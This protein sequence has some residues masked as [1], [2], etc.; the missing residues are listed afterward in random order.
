MTPRRFALL[1]CIIPSWIALTFADEQPADR[2]E[3]V[4]KRLVQAI[5]AG[6]T[7]AFRRDFDKAMLDALPPE[8][9]SS[10]VKD[11]RGQ[12]GKIE[13]LDPPR[14]IP[15]NQA[16][17]VAHLERAVLDIEIVLDEAGKISG[18]WFRPHVAPIP[19]PDRHQTVL[20]LPFEGA[21]FVAW[22]GDTRELNQ[23]HDTP[24]QRYAFDFLVTDA[25]GKTHK[26]DG[27]DNEDY[28]AFGRPVL[29]P[30]D[31][32]VTDVITG[33]RDNAPGSM[34]PY[35]ATGNTVIIEHRT[36]EVSVLAHFQQGS[37]RVKCGEHVEKG[38]VLGLCGNSGNSS[39]PH[40]HY[41]LQNTPIIQDG[42]G[43]RCLFE[44]VNV[45][46]DGKNESKTNYSPV[47]GDVVKPE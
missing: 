1:C 46:K 29:A 19:V 23:H 5:N 39:E 25:A 44:K 9:I 45:T 17:F 32:V 40:I 31:G 4:V 7:A 37:I 38:Q 10:L 18:L 2:F 22:G 3:K 6:D 26:S 14:L 12:C 28:F 43:I 16:V 13:R 33:V 21:W 24:N 47:K 41:H 34:N 27:K 30:A 11:L 35:S 20:R 15:P 42:T 8:K 36:H